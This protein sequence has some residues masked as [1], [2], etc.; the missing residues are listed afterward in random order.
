M[1]KTFVHDLLRRTD[2]L[3]DL[4]DILEHGHPSITSSHPWW[5]ALKKLEAM[6]IENIYKLYAEVRGV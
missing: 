5:V 6:E 3:E 1:K 2:S 4:L